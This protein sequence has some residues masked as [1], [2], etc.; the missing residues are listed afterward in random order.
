MEEVQKIFAAVDAD[1]SGA[2]DS[3]ELQAALASGG[4]T[5]SLTTCAMLI[6]LHDTGAPPGKL[7]FQEFYTLNKFLAEAQ[8]AFVAAGG[9]P[10]ATQLTPPQVRSA[11]S[12]L[13]YA[14]MD[15]PAFDATCK[16]FDPTCD[17]VFGLTEF[18]AMTAFLRS[19]LGTF[20]GF[21][22]GG[23]GAVTMSINQFL[24]AASNTR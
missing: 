24:Y 15:G 4:F 17:A 9:S 3:R 8:A 2:I 6:R 19:V 7:T 10:T 23:R 21:D 18:F 5:L 11:L 1:K 14:W 13:G 22:Q 16:A 12:A 20:K